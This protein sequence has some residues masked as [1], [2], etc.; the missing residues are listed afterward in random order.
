MSVQRKTAPHQC[1]AWQMQDSAQGGQYCAACGDGYP[2]GFPGVRATDTRREDVARGMYELNARRYGWSNPLD[3]A[4]V[5][6]SRREEYLGYADVALAEL[7]APPAAV[8]VFDQPEV[9][10]ELLYRLRTVAAY[11]RARGK[12]G[13]E[14]DP[15]F[16]PREARQGAAS[17]VSKARPAAPAPVLDVRREDG[18]SRIAI[19]RARQITEEGH[20]PER[21]IGRVDE[22]TR[23]AA[24]Y[25]LPTPHLTDAL[26]PWAEEDFKPSGIRLADLVKAGALI[27]AA[28]DAHLNGEGR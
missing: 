7:P 20:A 6:E 19:V 11:Y 18:A 13:E 25:A 14:P 16:I 1:E 12:H 24:T 2:E 23:A 27:A 9:E 4:E 10:H 26:W 28:I 22:L 17:I 8:S 3:W 5:H 15:E 21:D